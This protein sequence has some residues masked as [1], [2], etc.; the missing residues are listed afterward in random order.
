MASQSLSMLGSKT[1]GTYW[2][3]V[4]ANHAEKLVTTILF[5]T[6]IFSLLYSAGFVLLKFI[7]IAYIH[8]FSNATIQ[9]TRR[10]SS[11]EIQYLLF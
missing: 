2:L 3:S 1:R 5:S 7:A 10:H 8:T 11:L 4:P 6:V 9:H